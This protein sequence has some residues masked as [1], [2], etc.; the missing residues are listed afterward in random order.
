MP[1]TF[2]SSVPRMNFFDAAA[3]KQEEAMEKVGYKFSKEELEDRD[4]MKFRKSG[5][6]GVR[7]ASRLEHRDLV[8][9]AVA[10]IAMTP[11]GTDVRKA[12]LLEGDPLAVELEV[13]AGRKENGFTLLLSNVTTAR[14]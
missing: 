8:R 6:V 9:L 12:T 3:A 14:S 5:T 2:P 13:P 10:P 1:E 7:N 4:K 11:D